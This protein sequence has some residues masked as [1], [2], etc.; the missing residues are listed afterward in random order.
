MAFKTAHQHVADPELETMFEGAD[1]DEALRLWREE[2]DERTVDSERFS[3]LVEQLGILLEFFAA[4]RTAEGLAMRTWATLY[5]VRPDLIGHE[6]IQS[7]ADRFG[8]SQQ[9]VCEILKLFKDRI[10]F[11]YPSR[12][13][14][15]DAAKTRMRI[16]AMTRAR[17]AKAARFRARRE[18][19]A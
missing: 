5:A 14:A 15:C 17:I 4:A 13:G 7:A 1:R 10:G 11:E 9:R 8:V 2:R 16:E 6:T 18:E 3:E 19:A 12:V